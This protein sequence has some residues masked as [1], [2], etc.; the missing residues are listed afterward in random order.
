MCAN[1][2]ELSLRVAFKTIAELDFSVPKATASF[3]LGLN[4]LLLASDGALTSSNNLQSILTT[5]QP[6]KVCMQNGICRNDIIYHF[7]EDK[8]LA[9]PRSWLQRAEKKNLLHTGA[10]KF[11]RTFFSRLF[12]DGIAT[13][14]MPQPRL[15]ASLIIIIIII[16]TEIHVNFT[17]FY[18]FFCVPATFTWAAHT[19]TIEMLREHSNEVRRME[20]IRRPRAR[21]YVW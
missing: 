13:R 7:P 5:H 15:S 8:L 9:W 17:A 11:L 21:L 10:Q 14:T 2:V 20:Y 6:H 3:L 12:F 4:H 1:Y 18:R 16:I 19:R